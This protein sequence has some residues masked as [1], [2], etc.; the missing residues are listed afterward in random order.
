MREVGVGEG[1]KGDVE[2]VGEAGETRGVVGAKVGRG[3]REGREVTW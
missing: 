3:M 2:A 1:V